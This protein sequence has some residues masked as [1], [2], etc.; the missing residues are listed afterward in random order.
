MV[1]HDPKAKEDGAI[2]GLL[3]VYVEGSK[4][5]QGQF[6]TVCDATF[7]DYEQTGFG[8]KTISDKICEELGY[9]RGQFTSANGASTG[10]DIGLINK[11]NKN[12]CSN[13]EH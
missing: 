5:E 4:D 7:V 2:E 6:G 13:D 1:I 12:A 3:L 10:F 9:G 8:T 11:A